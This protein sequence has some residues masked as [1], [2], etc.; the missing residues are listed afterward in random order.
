MHTSVV[1]SLDVLEYTVLFEELA[2]VY[3]EQGMYAEALRI[4]LD[5]AAHD[6]VSHLRSR[7]TVSCAQ[8][9]GIRVD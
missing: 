6:E 7:N 2:D 1:L 3:F 5:L 8:E 4:Y 9:F